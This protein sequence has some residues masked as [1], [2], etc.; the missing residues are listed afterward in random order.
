MFISIN[1]IPV[2]AGREDDFEKMFRERDRAVETQPGFVSLDILKPGNRIVRGGGSEPVGNNEYQVLTRWEDETAF[3]G[4]IKSDAFKKSHSRIV[5]TSVF[6]GSSY[7]TCHE[8]IE[9]AGARGPVE[10]PSLV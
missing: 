5:D 8:S 2:K 3:R 6:D 9:G 7:L 10:E 1:H 4:W